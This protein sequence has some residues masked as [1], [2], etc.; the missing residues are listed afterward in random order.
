MN[1]ILKIFGM[2]GTGILTITITLVAIALM[3]LSLASS[4]GL[5]ALGVYFFIKVF[6]GV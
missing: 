1:K 2:I 3:L 6:F 4:I 5:F